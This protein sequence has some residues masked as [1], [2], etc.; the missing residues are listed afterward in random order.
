MDRPENPLQLEMKP[1]ARFTPLALSALLLVMAFPGLLRAE[2]TID[3]SSQVRPILS[4]KC[5]HCHGPDAQNQDS[6]FR[7]DTQEQLVADL[8]GYAGVV[9]GDLEASELHA[10]IHSVDPGDQMPPPDSNRSL[11]EEQKRILDLWIKQGAPYEEHWSFIKPQRPEVP[12]DDLREAVGEPGWDQAIVDAWSRNP[13]DAFIGRRLL[14]EGL[15]PSPQ[16]DPETRLRRAS[17]TLTGMLPTEDL[18]EDFRDESGLVGY[19]EAVSRLLDSD[20]FA[21][22]QTLR[23]LD[24]ARYADTDGYQND[25]ARTNWPWRDWVIKAFRDNMPFDQFTIEQIAGDM[26]PGANDSQRLAS[27]FNRNHRQN[28]EGGALAEEFMVENVIDRVE[29]TSVVWLGLTMGCARCHDHKYDPLSQKEFYQLYGFFNNIGE[30]GIGKGVDANPTMKAISPLVE[31]DP[32][33]VVAAKS[34]ERALEAAE[35]TLKDRLEPWVKEQR[36]ALAASENQAQTSVSWEPAPVQNAVVDGRGELKRLDEST[37][38]YE[39]DGNGSVG[40]RIELKADQ[41]S[42]ASLRLEALTDDRF[43]GPVR[44]SPSSN[45]NFVLTDVKVL[46]DGKAVD[47]KAVHASYE[48]PGYAA[49][50]ATDSNRKTGWAVAKSKQANE[51]VSLNL[52]LEEA[53]QPGPNSR[54]ELVL[55][56][57]SQFPQHTIGKL[58]VHASSEAVGGAPN[59]GLPDRVVAAI[60]KPAKRRSGDERK[61]LTEHHTSVDEQ[62]KAA[63]A[64]FDTAKAQLKAQGAQLATVMVMRERSGE[65]NSA[66]LLDRG[67]YNQPVKEE[68]LPRGVPEALLSE[69]SSQPTD[70]LELGKWLVSRDNPLTARVIINRIWQDHFGIGLVKTAEDFGLQGEMPSHPDLLD[71]LAVEFIE[72]GWDIKAMHLLIV[73]SAAYQQSS[74]TNEALRMADPENRLLARGP[75]YRADGFIIRDIALQASGLLS[76]KLGGPPVKPYQPKGLWEVVAANAGTRYTLGRGEDLFRRSMYSYWKRAVNPPRQTIFDAGGREVCDVRSRRTNTP[77]QALVLLNDP[78]FVETAR[79][80]AERAIAQTPTGSDTDRLTAMY[81]QAITRDIDAEALDVLQSS[82]RFFREHYRDRPDDAARLLAIG[83][84]PRDESIPTVEHAALTAVAQVI[85]NLDEFITIE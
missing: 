29:T 82:L 31:V 8:G 45:G 39:G 1:N 19:E 58:R 10:R 25:H 65:P 72:S 26:L 27:A 60:K 50:R 48:Q 55:R 18:R 24:A 35:Q 56:F 11:T 67:Q 36:E 38:F 64:A 44:M 80:L 71:W 5:F 57:D 69:A 20:A 33:L 83:E 28:G 53:I 7:A 76:T 74:K 43:A 68:P 46:L 81:G 14:D 6:E 66:Y 37:L 30:K 73:T 85:I 42:I 63:K 16:A 59:L 75:R 22:R 51:S 77:L 61:A 12:A 2:E 49:V 54:L 79:Q 40:Y 23:W 15:S 70:R 9:P 32:E 78:T 84:S 47:A 34:A 41:E 52:L 62:L 3:F 17:L 4:D 13:I 21:E